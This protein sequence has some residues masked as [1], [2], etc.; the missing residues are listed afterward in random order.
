MEWWL[1]KCSDG[2]VCLLEIYMSL[3]RRTLFGGKVVRQLTSAIV[4]ID[5]RMDEHRCRMDG[6]RMRCMGYRAHPW[7]PILQSNSLFPM[8]QL[9]HHMV[10]PSPANEEPRWKPEQPKHSSF[11]PFF[12]SLKSRTENTKPKIP[13]PLQNTATAAVTG[14]RAL[15]IL[16]G[17][18]DDDN[19]SLPR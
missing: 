15:H 11:L 1:Y 14:R 9:N 7:G 10:P 19:R 12:F 5:C 4:L 16:N 6:H 13:E 17:V 18:S 3:A 2:R 8:P